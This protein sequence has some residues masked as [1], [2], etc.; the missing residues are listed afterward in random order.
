M[1]NIVIVI[2]EPPDWAVAEKLRMGVGL[3]LDDNNSISV[4]MTDNGVFT[5]LGLDQSKVG[6]EIDKH[7]ETLKALNVTL[8]VHQPSADERNLAFT[9]FACKPLS[10]LDVE[11]VLATNDI[12]IT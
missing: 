8:Y 4:L 5:G 12:T 10:S 6:L 2:S 1:K 7:L 9:K 3:T 11:G